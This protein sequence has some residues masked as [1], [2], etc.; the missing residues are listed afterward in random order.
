MTSTYT[1][2]AATIGIGA[3]GVF[4]FWALGLP[5]PFLLGPMFFCLLAA[6]GGAKMQDFGKLG[7]AFRTILG[8]AAGSSITP[9]VV[10]ALPGMALSL[11]TVPVF[12]LATAVTSYPLLR[13]LF[14]F[15]PVTSYY[16]AMPGGLQD[17]IVFG[18]AA[19]ANLRVL[20]LIHAT[21]VLC[22][23][24]IAPL[25]LNL[26]WDVDL[27]APPGMPG[28]ETPP[29]Q[30]ALMVFAG[31][32][33]WWGANRLNIL[34]AS[35]IGPMILTAAL[36]ISGIITQ[37]P[38][39]EMI[40]ASQ[41]VI[42]I[43]V[44]AKYVGVTWSELQRVV[45][46]GVLNAGLLAGVSAVFIAAAVA[47]SLSPVLDAFLAFLPGGQGEMVVLAIIAGADLT[48]VVL[49]HVLRIALVVVGA[50]LFLQVF[51]KPQK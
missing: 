24:S 34:G 9:D 11:L 31:L 8:V 51:H 45:V 30:I 19:G 47:M 7:F 3:I 39:A 20:S 37:R 2:R 22:I 21:R 4:A 49:H 1:K 43:G 41:F 14:R 33:G 10:Q 36:S 5:L 38:P 32:A 6:L 40:W 46:A 50:P 29:L 48:Y 27:T 26:W 35:I 23:V 44:G 28:I 13:R 15:D 17:L 18:E 25:V 12:I 42:G 16:S